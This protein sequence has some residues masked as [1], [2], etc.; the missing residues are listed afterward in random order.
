[1]TVTKTSLLANGAPSL[2]HNT[3]SNLTP[4]TEDLDSNQFHDTQHSSLPVG[5]Q[6]HCPALSI[7][8][9]LAVGRPYPFQ[10]SCTICNPAERNLRLMVTFSCFTS[11]QA[12]TCLT[13]MFI[14]QYIQ[15]PKLLTSV[16]VLPRFRGLVKVLPT[17]PSSAT[18][19]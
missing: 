5:L 6:G 12:R 8:R 7:C 11:R 19:G 18:T 1:M 3:Q 16:A 14:G 9:N 13:T 2:I 15:I 17:P 4:C 10:N